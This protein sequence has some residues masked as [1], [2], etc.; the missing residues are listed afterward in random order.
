MRHL[1]PLHPLCS[2]L[3]RLAP[4]ELN[5]SNRMELYVF[6]NEARGHALLVARADNLGKGASGSAAQNIDA[7]LGLE[8]GSDYALEIN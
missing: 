7:M 8:T 3:P 1:I 2:M 6:A 5:G 4:E